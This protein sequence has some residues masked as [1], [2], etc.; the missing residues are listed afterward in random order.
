MKIAIFGTG[1]VGLVTG[2]CLARTG[3]QVVGVDIDQQKIN[4]L[5]K[6]ECP[7]HEKDLP[8]RLRHGIESKALKFS[9]D[10]PDALKNVDII[11][12][13]V[14]TPP[15]EDGNAD[16]SAI[17]AVAKTI[18][19]YVDSDCVVVQKSTVPVGT[20]DQ[21]EEVIGKILQKRKIKIHC[22]VVS[23][24]EFLKEGNAVKDFESPERVIIGTENEWAASIMRK[25]YQ[26]FMRQKERILVMSRKSAELS[27]VLANAMLATRIS[28]M[29]L[30]SRLCENVGADIKDIR[31]ALGSDSRIG[32]GFLYPGIGFGGS[33]FPKDIRALVKTLSKNNLPSELLDE[34]L[35]I[36]QKQR[37]W[38]CRKIKKTMGALK[39]KKIAIWG[40]A[41]KAGTDDVREAPSLEIVNYLLNR[42]ALVFAYD[43][44]AEDSFR[45]A[46]GRRKRMEYE[47]NQYEV[48][49]GAD[50]L[51][52][53][54]DEMIFRNPD[55][56]GMVGLMKKD[57]PIIDGR[58]LYEPKDLLEKGI[59][60]HC[61]GRIQ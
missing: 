9:S 53:L 10:A 58:N 29:N 30:A 42:H 37:E 54:T 19:K 11:F 35:N 6:G 46:I 2:S 22:E 57:A 39:G 27:K 23:N 13:C 28:F 21:I 60:Y 36:N 25:I 8:V 61:V 49:E 59:E 31:H 56:D 44:V 32:P 47:T 7:I 40:L 5:K 51:I 41:F 43:P 15:L 1:Y 12:I 45:Q 18:G 3:I 52:I 48:L 50:A 16:L 24:P 55:F 33:C 17:F 14:G 20:G 26:P 38:F 34:V 4:S